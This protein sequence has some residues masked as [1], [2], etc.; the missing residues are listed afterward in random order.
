MIQ[1]FLG[2]IANATSIAATA[3]T[4]ITEQKLYTMSVMR[5]NRNLLC[6]IQSI[7]IHREPRLKQYWKK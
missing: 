5:R 6:G 3:A 4:K 1:N 2:L 7:M